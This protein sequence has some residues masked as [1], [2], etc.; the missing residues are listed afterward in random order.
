MGIKRT[1]LLEGVYV[2]GGALVGES[3]L[4]DSSGVA[5]RCLR[6]ANDPH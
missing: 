3:P 5:R 2:D 1:Y 6:L 4:V